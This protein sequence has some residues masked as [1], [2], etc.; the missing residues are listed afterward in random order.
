[1]LK[2]YKIIS[3]HCLLPLKSSWVLLPKVP[4]DIQCFFCL[5][6]VVIM[7]DFTLRLDSWCRWKATKHNKTGIYSCKR[8]GNLEWKR[9]EEQNIKKSVFEEVVG[10]SWCRPLDV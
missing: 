8:N 7:A 6:V 1:M 5:V 9:N 4:K 10:K 3:F 2:I